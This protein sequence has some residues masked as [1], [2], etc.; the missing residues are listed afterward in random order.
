MEKS[1]GIPSF[2]FSSPEHLDL[3]AAPFLSPSNF[4]LHASETL[5]DFFEGFL[6]K[7]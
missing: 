2:S 5:D 6:K 3:N 7:N 4:S 1:P